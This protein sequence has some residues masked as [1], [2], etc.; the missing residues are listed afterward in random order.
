MLVFKRPQS[1][2]PV[3]ATTNQMRIRI[4]MAW[5]LL[6]GNWPLTP[7]LLPDWC[8]EMLPRLS[9]G[10]QQ[11][12]PGTSLF[13]TPPAAAVKS[14]PSCGHTNSPEDVKEDGGSSV[15]SEV[16]SRVADPVHFR[17]D[18]ANPDPGSYGH[19]KN[20]FKHQ[21]LFHIKHISSDIWMMIIFIWKSG[22]IHRKMCKTS[23][24]KIFFPCLYNL[25]LP[26]CR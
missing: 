23:I 25:R 18:P 8:I 13:A 10:H 7:S 16:S 2:N 15:A 17:P 11:N 9:S 4:Q 1:K 20:Q 12:L 6:A 24:F 21:N 5:I 22:K 19:L 3:E 14:E 26:K